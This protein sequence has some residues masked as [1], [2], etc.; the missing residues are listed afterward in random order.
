MLAKA[1]ESELIIL[2]GLGRLKVAARELD[3]LAREC[4]RTGEGIATINVGGVTLNG[5]IEGIVPLS[6]RL[7]VSARQLDELALE[8]DAQGDSLVS[9]TFKVE[10]VDEWLEGE[11]ATVH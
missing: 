11:G 1:P 2:S 8:D 4:R 6:W 9:L 7:K 3:E 5:V 10:I